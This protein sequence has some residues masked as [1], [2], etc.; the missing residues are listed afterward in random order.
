M[1]IISILLSVIIEFLD[2][3]ILLSCTGTLTPAGL[4]GQFWARMKSPAE[5]A[6]DIGVTFDFDMTSTAINWYQTIPSQSILIVMW[7]FWG[8]RPGSAGRIRK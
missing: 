1:T 3:T 7:L 6:F 2:F 5:L 4:R 8:L